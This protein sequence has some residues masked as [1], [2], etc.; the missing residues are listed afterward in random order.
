MS[1][2]ASRPRDLVA[3]DIF[4]VARDDVVGLTGAPVVVKDR[5][6]DAARRDRD[7][8][9]V[10]DIGDLALAQR[11]LNR[12]FDLD[13]GTPQKPLTVAEALALRVGPTIDNVHRT[14]SGRLALACAGR[15][16]PALL[17]RMYHSTSR[18]TWRSV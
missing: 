16:Y 1:V 10:F 18:R 9:A 2:T 17:T 15:A 8:L 11:L 3:A 6:G 7:L 12:R 13:A 5:L 14:I 4:L